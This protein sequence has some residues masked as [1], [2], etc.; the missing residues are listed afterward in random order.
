MREFASFADAVAAGAD[1][2]ALAHYVVDTVSSFTRGGD[3]ALDFLSQDAVGAFCASLGIKR[4]WATLAMDE[5]APLDEFGVNVVPRE[6]ADK[7]LGLLAALIRDGYLKPKNNGV[8]APDVL[9]DFL[10]TPKTFQGSPTLGH[11]DEFAYALAVEL[12][13]GRDRGQNVTM[14]HPLMTGMVVMAHLAED[15]IYYARLRVMESEGDVFDLQL[16]KRPFAQ[17]HDSLKKKA[18]AEERLNTRLSEKLAGLK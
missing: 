7:I 17:I 12:E 16:K 1:A 3:V 6:E 2:N 13:H 15:T 11:L 5:I 4:N 9:N 14:N 8:A 10:S 18:D